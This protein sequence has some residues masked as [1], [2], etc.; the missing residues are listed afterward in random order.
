MQMN[1]EKSPVLENQKNHSDQAPE[2]LRKRAY[3]NTITSWIDIGAK[4]I[5]GFVLNPYIVSI[6]G[7]VFYGVWQILGQLNSYMVMADLRT[8]TTLKWVIAKERTIAPPK[9]LRQSVTA[10]ISANVL[11]L[12]LYLIAGFIIIWLAPYICKVEEQYFALVRITSA[13]LVMVFIV[14]QFLF[15]FES[16]LMAMNLAYK[17]MGIR[18]LITVFGGALTA[19][20][21]YLGFGLPGMAVVLVIV[22]IVTGAII[23]W[24][25]YANVP[26]FGFARVTWSKVFGFIKLTGWF[27]V[28]KI[29]NTANTS[30]D[31]ILLG[32]LAGPKY[33]AAYAIS[34]FLVSA[35]SSFC[36]SAF[37]AVTPGLSRL[38]G[39]KNYATL[40]SARSQMLSLL[41]IYLTATG[42]IVCVWNKSFIGIW[43][44]PVYFAGQ[45]E[46]SLIVFLVMLK[47]IQDV[48]GS[49]IVMALNI[50]R[51]VT[52]GV[53]AVLITVV[54]AWLLIPL[55][56]TRGLL[57]SLLT[58]SLSMSI[59]Y[60]YY[61]AR[62]TQGKVSFFSTTYL[63]R[64]PVVCMSVLIIFS[65]LGSYV[66]VDS[67]VTLICGI[68]ATFVAVAAILWFFAMNSADR[69]KAIDNLPSLLF[70][71]KA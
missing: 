24:L 15:V 18:A 38:L 17:S 26:W 5:V 23:G 10:S 9:E 13:L 8:S 53:F 44:S 58:G 6:L 71:K 30:I 70:F 57:L 21:L 41:W 50:K 46:T 68:L 31:L 48:D 12:P 37:N 64:T 43:T 19:G 25:V 59:G 32:Y 49:I 63:S 55:Y 7:P 67:W 45:I 16:V 62:L 34:R 65:F 1:S 28:L 60:S 22:P 35:L 33:V 27:M 40:L 36:S 3:L 2:N 39:E 29:V 61:A 66:N 11:I 4:M 56:Q 69:G 42:A 14:T 54:L 20:A 47:S 51:N 52:I